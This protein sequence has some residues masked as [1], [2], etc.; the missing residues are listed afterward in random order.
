MKRKLILLNVIVVLAMILGACAAP[1]APAPAAPQPAAPT[2][3][4]AAKPAGPLNI[5]FSI[6]GL[7][8]PF[9]VFMD[10]QVK[11][12][13][14]KLGMDIATLDGQNQVPKQTA[15]VEAAIAKKVNGILISPIT[16]D[17]MAPAVKEAVDAGIPVVTVDRTVTGVDT[18]AH[19]GADNVLGGEQQGKALLELFPKGAVIFELLG[20][21]GASPAIDRSKGLHNI[22]DSHPEIKV[23]CQQTG[24]FN[25]DK[26]LT[27]TE[28]CLGANPNPDAIIA[29]NDDM[30][31]GAIEALKAKD[32]AGKVKVIGY[33]ALPESL[34]AIQSGELYGTVEQ[35]PGQQARKGLAVLNDFITKGAKPEKHEIFIAP[36]LIT[37][38]NLGEAERGAEAGISAAPAAKPAGPLNIAF[39]IPGLQFPFFVFMDTQVKDEAK[40][41]GMD[42]ATLDGQ[43]QVPKQ[44]ADVEAAIAKNVSGILISPI[45]ADGMAPA[46]QEAVDAGIPVVTVDRT[47]TG[48]DTLAHVGADNVLGGEQQGKALLELF[49]KG[50]VI[51]ELLGTPGASP[52]ID[53][54]KGLHNIIDSHPEIK[55]ACQQTGEFNRDKGLTVTENCLGANPNPDAIIA[56][57]DDMALGAIEALK[58]KDLAGKVKVIGYDALP[59]SLKAIQSGELYGTVEQ[60]PGQQARKGLAVLNDFITKGAK[61]EKH[62]IFIAPKLITQANLA[63][64]ERGAEAGISAAPAPAAAGE[65]GTIVF[66]PKSTDVSYWLFVKAGVE[67]AAKELGYKTDYQGVPREIDIAQQVDL[68]RNIASTKPAG[69]VMAATDAKALVPA[70]EDAIKMGVP[71]VTV[72]SG[73]DSDAPLAYFATDNVAGGAEGARWLCK[74]IGGKGKVGDLGILAGSQTGR[75]R[76]Q[77]FADTM[78]KECPDVKV[79]PVQY[80]GCDPA[81]ALNA[82]TDMLTANPDLVG[83]YSACGPNGLGIAQA[84]KAA[85]KDKQVQIIT[86]D[87]NPEVIPMFEQGTIQAMI[88]QDPYQM[89]YKGAKAIDTVINGGKIE[90]KVLLIPV[91][92][93]TP[94]NYQNPDIQKLMKP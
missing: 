29:A 66:I 36:K 42:I 78:A 27:V 65:K 35:F 58:A 87:P 33:D 2:E 44:T 82:A 1:P 57:N 49:P 74:A 53:R 14:K 26:G 41:L 56:A 60:F 88:A 22:I 86:F 40:K 83:F 79:V 59:E 9:F 75:E 76:E 54:S 21:P 43:N 73:V 51:F 67:A 46:V 17:G 30:A 48:V 39:S 25:R 10:T 84:V 7:Q 8:F 28:N 16:A 94:D 32:L 38:A 93:I 92:I 20:T 34:K 31:L 52:A 70:V 45:T 71:L 18:L 63:E 77:G 19:V 37:Q 72:D 23:A 91:K 64:A 80:T 6:P 89:G 85:G 12:E 3:V 24:E 62:E 81:K 68:V 15:D 13:A 55:V 11:D 5:A 47:V 69:I 50:A 61:P 4:P 90:P